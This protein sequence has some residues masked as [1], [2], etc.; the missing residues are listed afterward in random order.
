MLYAALRGGFDSATLDRER[1]ILPSGVQVADAGRFTNEQL[2][3]FNQN[4]M[5][6][7]DRYAMGYGGRGLQGTRPEGFGSQ[8]L[9]L[10]IQLLIQE[11]KPNT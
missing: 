5:T 2:R 6:A 4:Y 3:Q 11:A 1:G 7:G 8:D 10:L 9:G